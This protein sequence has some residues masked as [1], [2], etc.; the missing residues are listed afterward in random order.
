MLGGGGGWFGSFLV[1]W[2][3]FSSLCCG[4]VSVLLNFFDRFSDQPIF[5]EV[6][7]SFCLS[8]YVSS[9]HFFLQNNESVW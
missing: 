8:I 6:D 9:T 4:L 5:Y 7:E 3:F 1:V 2:F